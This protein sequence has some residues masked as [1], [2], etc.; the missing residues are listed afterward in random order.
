MATCFFCDGTGKV[1][2]K[3]GSAVHDDLEGCTN[4]DGEPE[5][6]DCEACEDERKTDSGGER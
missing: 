3:C 1:C 6:V 2:F 5:V 4:C